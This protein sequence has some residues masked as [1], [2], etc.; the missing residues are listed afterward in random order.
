MSEGFRV[1]SCLLLRRRICGSYRV[2]MKR[3]RVSFREQ[4][5]F[6]RLCL[7]LRAECHLYRSTARIAP[8]PVSLH[9]STARIAPP[10]V[11]LHRLYRSTARI[12]P[13]PVSL[14]HPYRSV[15]VLGV[16]LRQVRL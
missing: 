3:C 4:K 2:M 10:P 12:A 5:F 1:T 13:P 7:S 9:R 11:S 16:Y 14:H 6:W 15:T 8:P